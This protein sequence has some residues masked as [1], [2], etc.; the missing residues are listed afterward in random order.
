MKNRLLRLASVRSIKFEKEDIK[1]KGDK[2]LPGHSN[3]MR[4][5]CFDKQGTLLATN[6]YYSIGGG[7]VVDEKLKTDNTFYMLD[8]VHSVEHRKNSLVTLPFTNAE[9]LLRVCTDKQ[10]EISDVKLFY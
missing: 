7:F 10:I 3:G 5:S 8:E 4:Y 9:D 6:V 2:V 1:Y